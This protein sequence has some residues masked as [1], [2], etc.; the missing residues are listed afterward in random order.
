MHSALQHT[1]PEKDNKQANKQAKPVH[2]FGSK[3]PAQPVRHL[4]G[5]PGTGGREESW[6]SLGT[7]ISRR[8][9]F[10][11]VLV[12]LVAVVVCLELTQRTT[13]TVQVAQL[14][15]HVEYRPRLRSGVFL[16]T[17]C[18]RNAP[19][20]SAWLSMAQPK[21]SVRAPGPFPANSS[22]HGSARS[23]CRIF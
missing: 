12:V 11:G 18:T 7:Q 20:G 23:K 21:K 16:H 17:D 5:P 10:A 9:C 1:R 15:L 19:H 22:R 14:S 4:A 3:R 6:D 2:M 13:Q 8:M